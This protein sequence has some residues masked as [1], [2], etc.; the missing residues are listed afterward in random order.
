MSCTEV[1]RT[2]THIRYI[3][4]WPLKSL[5]R[6]VLLPPFFPPSLTPSRNCTRYSGQGG[7]PSCCSRSKAWVRRC[8]GDA[9]ARPRP[10]CDTCLCTITPHIRR[11]FLTKSRLSR[12]SHTSEYPKVY[13]E[14]GSLWPITFLVSTLSFVLKARL[15][16]VEN[17]QTSRSFS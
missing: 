3:Q 16:L 1:Y 14:S 6:Q 11:P 7:A 17:P 2:I 4:V 12:S 8:S 13:G 15:H 10:V 5:S 9:Q